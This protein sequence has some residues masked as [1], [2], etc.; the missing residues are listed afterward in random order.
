MHDSPGQRVPP[1]ERPLTRALV[2][3]VLLAGVGIALFL[4]RSGGDAE[5]GRPTLEGAP[6][7]SGAAPTAFATEDPDIELGALD[8]NPPIIGQ[9]APDFALR[10]LDGEIVRLSDLRGSVVFIN[11]WA[12]WCTPCKKELPD[13][14]KLYDEKREQGLVVLE[15]NWQENADDARAFFESRD[16]ELAVLIDRP[17]DVYDQYRLQGLPDS[18]F[19]DRDGNLASL[20]FGYLSEEKMRERLETAG[21]P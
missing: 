8:D 1:L 15:I 9:Q 13:I 6:T 17:G 14:Q 10:N 4:I 11:F 12:T 16:L 19:V 7:V 5:G 21:L 20:H 18:F 3:I 2:G